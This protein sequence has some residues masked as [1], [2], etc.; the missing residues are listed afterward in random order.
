MTSYYFK[1][2]KHVNGEKVRE[3]HLSISAVVLSL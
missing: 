3:I 1:N 2:V